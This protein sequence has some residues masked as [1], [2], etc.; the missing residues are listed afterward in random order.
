MASD[1]DVLEFDE[2]AYIQRENANVVLTRDGWI[3]RVGRLSSVES[4]RVREGDEVIAVV[5]GS[6]LDHVIFFADDGTAYTL[7]VNEVPASHGYGEPIAKF[8]KLADQVKIINAVTTDERFIPAEEKGKRGDPPGPYL[9][10]AT[11]HGMVLRTPLAPYRTASTKNGRRY[12]RLAEGDRAVLATVPRGEETMFLA[13]RD[14]HVVH[15]ALAEVNILTGVGKGVTGIKLR[16]GDVCLGGALSGN[17][18]DALVV[19]TTGGIRKEI[20]RGAYPATHRG[21]KGYEIVK[22]ADLLRVVPPP[23]ELVD[24]EQM[25]GGRVEARPAERNGHAGKNGDGPTLCE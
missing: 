16:K 4:T 20:R 5:P 6:T 21:G 15:F 8:F 7:R 13:S 22:R 1:E 23:I 12:V 3:K 17:R 9:L 25:D 19:E 24:W 11:A 2:E 14:G 18:F 10:V